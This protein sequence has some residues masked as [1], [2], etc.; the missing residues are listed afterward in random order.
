VVVVV[1]DAGGV[2]ADVVLGLASRR[3]VALGGE[4]GDESTWRAGGLLTRSG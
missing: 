3:L 2:L 1:V 4:I